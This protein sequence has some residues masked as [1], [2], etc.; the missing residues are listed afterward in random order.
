MAKVSR[1]IEDRNARLLSAIHG[2]YGEYIDCSQIKYCVDG[3]VI[4]KSKGEV[5]IN[6]ND[7][8]PSLKIRSPNTGDYTESFQEN[9][10]VF[11][12]FRKSDVIKLRLHIHRME[13]TNK[14]M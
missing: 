7:L 9:S 12:D 11:T 13:P 8:S 5:R 6:R 2:K 10:C 4:F 1:D 14:L 3:K